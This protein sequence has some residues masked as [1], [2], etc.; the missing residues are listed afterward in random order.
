MVKTGLD[1]GDLTL[2]FKVKVELN[3][4]NLNKIDLVSRIYGWE[5]QHFFGV[6]NVW[7][8]NKNFI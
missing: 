8:D 7:E 3:W 6:C 5:M 2:I 4:S 1:F